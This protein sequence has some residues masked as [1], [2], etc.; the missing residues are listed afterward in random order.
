[1]IVFGIWDHV[2]LAVQINH[3]DAAWLSL[4]AQLARVPGLPVH[5]RMLSCCIVQRESL[6]GDVPFVLVWSSAYHF[7]FK[8]ETRKTRHCPQRGTFF[9]L[10]C[11][12]RNA[13]RV[14]H[15]EIFCLLHCNLKIFV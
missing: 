6:G 11:Y 3:A 2:E 9:S 1:V 8:H 14:S 4:V 5:G 10:T 13:D 15:L 12:E 7:N